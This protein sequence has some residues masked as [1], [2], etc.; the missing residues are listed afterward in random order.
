MPFKFN[1]LLRAILA[2]VLYTIAGFIAGP[3]AGM[4]HVN[5]DP[6]FTNAAT[7]DFTLQAGSP[8]KLA[9]YNSGITTDFADNARHATTPSIG[10]YE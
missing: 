6:L 3:G 8:A 9:G 10:A 7:G 4:G 2:G 1:N 5:A